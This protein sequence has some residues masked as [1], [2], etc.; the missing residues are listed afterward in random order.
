MK[1]LFEFNQDSKAKELLFSEPSLESHNW[2]R[3]PGSMIRSRR[4]P[5]L[6][7][8]TDFLP[9]SY[10]EISTSRSP[11][12]SGIIHTVHKCRQQHWSLADFQKS[13][14]NLMWKGPVVCAHFLLT[15]RLI[16]VWKRPV[17]ISVTGTRIKLAET[18]SCTAKLAHN[19]TLILQANENGN[20]SILGSSSTFNCVTLYS[21]FF[22]SA[23]CRFF[24]CL[25][26]HRH[27]NVMP[28]FLTLSVSDSW[29]WIQLE[30]FA[31]LKLPNDTSITVCLSWKFLLLLSFK[32]LKATESFDQRGKR[33]LTRFKACYQCHVPAWR[34]RGGT[35]VCLCI[36]NCI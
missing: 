2:P 7:P 17:Y 20:F 31:V 32:K 34:H 3:S 25:R 9:V 19:L 6:L 14:L 1:L 22:G 30:M 13:H 28:N 23:L 15:V 4:Y 21:G 29:S 26:Q 24:S 5:K 16:G 27:W 12:N 36:K 10:P 35:R 18:S 8:T 33:I 11:P